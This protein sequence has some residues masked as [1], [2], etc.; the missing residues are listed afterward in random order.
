M[1]QWSRGHLFAHLASVWAR[2]STSFRTAPS[3]ARALLPPAAEVNAV[4]RGDAART[5]A[6]IGATL[7]DGRG[8]PALPNAAVVVRGDRIVAAG[9]RDAVDVPLG[10]EIVEAAGQT[11]LPGLIDAHFHL[12][13][14]NGLLALYLKHGVTSLRDPGAWIEAYDA[15]RATPVPIPR[16]FLTGPHLDWP[17][18]AYPSDAMLVRDPVEARRAVDDLVTRG[19]SGIKIYFRLPLGMIE[20]VTAAAH[21]RGV[22]T[23]AHLETVDARDAVRAGLDG[24]EHVTSF[25]QSLVPPR[26]AER[27]RQAVIADNSARRNGRYQMW[28]GIVADSPPAVELM[29]L[30][31]SRSTFVT[32]TLA[33]FERRAGEEGASEAYVRGFANMM[34]FV[35]AARRA[36]VRIVVGSHSSVPHAER[37]RAYQREIELLVESGLTPME[38]LVAGTLES[39]RF[40]Q[41]ADRLGSVERGKVADLILVDGDPLKDISAMRRVKRVMLN[42]LWVEPPP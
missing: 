41:I 39:A 40:L 29:E 3:R 2:T 16:L 7:I 24:V 15:A 25:G 10:A 13:G 33:I 34:A 12:D 22:I 36:G 38:T 23:T 20:V 27:Y 42:G 26:E 6:I 37:G 19:A 11:L 32:P 4:A 21:E 31:V 28:S 17:P 35:G 18:P 5:V 30:L 9:A 14:D 8:G 1:I